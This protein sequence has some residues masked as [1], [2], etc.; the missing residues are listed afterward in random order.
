VPTVQ[1]QNQNWSGWGA[2]SGPYTEV[3]TS[4]VVPSLTTSTSCGEIDATWA[5]IDGVTNANLVQAGVDETPYDP[6]TG[7]CTA[8]SS[9]YTYAWWEILPAAETAITAWDSGPLSGQP[10]IVSPGDQ[11]TVDI[12]LSGGIATIAL[13][14]VTTGGVFL[15]NQAYSGQANTTEAVQEAVTNPTLCGGQCGLAP[16][17]T[18]VNGSCVPEVNVSNMGAAGTINQYD[19]FILAQGGQVLAEPTN[20]QSGQFSV[21]YTGPYAAPMGGVGV[22]AGIGTPFTGHVRFPLSAT[23]APTQTKH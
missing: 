2:Q 3:S 8:P 9:F 11:I 15:T 14:D 20:L 23:S 7:T 17:C 18:E 1:V 16:F 22:K 19:E 13:D 6:Y 5:G 10:A 12:S 21:D 4:F